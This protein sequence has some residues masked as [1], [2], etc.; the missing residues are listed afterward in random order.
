M[1]PSPIRYA[2]AGDVHI[3]YRTLGEGPVDLVLISGS[4]SNVELDWDQPQYV[5]FMERLALAG[6]V[7]TFDRR[8]VG[9]SD[10]V[11]SPSLEERMDDVRAVLDDLGSRRAVLFGYGDGG[12]MGTL[13]TATYPDRVQA[14][15]LYWF[16]PRRRWAPDYP[17]GLSAEAARRYLD[18]ALAGWNDL[19]RA[20]REQ[21]AVTAP[22]AIADNALQDWLVRW[23]RLSVSPGAFADFRRVNLEVDVRHVLPSIRA[24]TLV[25]HRVDQ[26]LVPA[27]VSRYVAERIP[28]AVYVELSGR[29]VWPFLEGSEEMAEAIV[30]FVEESGTAPEVEFERVLV[31][32]LFTDIVAATERAAELGDARWRELLSEH[33]RVVRRLLARFR[34][35]ELDTAGDGFFASFDGPARAIRC[36]TALSDELRELGLEVRAGLHTGEC[37]VI[38]GKVAGIAV[39]IGARVAAEAAPGEVLVSS[40]VRDLVAGS[41]LQ[42]ED[43]GEHELKG[44]PGEWRLYAVDNSS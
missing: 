33:H 31:T 14:L 7:I 24:P 12:A 29:D 4:I 28:T 41:G 39:H 27:E 16:E 1:Q 8:G 26:E 15:V 42:F 5:E 36:A 34:G 30:R 40:T 18:E 3:A 11:P 13:F 25:L 32:I 23:Q 2:K 22:S 44:M 38:D 9:I 17:W 6:R 20:S 21:L 19:E 43:R 35:R 10:R 37:E